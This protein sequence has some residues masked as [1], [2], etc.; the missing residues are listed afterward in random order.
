MICGDNGQGK[1][2]LLEGIA[3]FSG[4]RSFRGAHNRQMICR[5]QEYARLEADFFAEK[6]SQTASLALSADKKELTLNGVKQAA[7]SAMIG[8]FCCVVFSPDRMSLISGG[9]VE[10]RRFLDAAIS[11]CLPRFVSVLYSYN[12]TLGHRNALLKSICSGSAS[13]ADLGLWDIYASGYAADIALKR[14]EYCARLSKAAG[15]IYDGIS[16]GRERLELEYSCSY[17]KQGDSREDIIRRFTDMLTESRARDILLGYTQK[18][19]QRDDIIIK[20]SGADIR[21]YGSRGQKRSA[22]LALKLA[23]AELLSEQLEEKPIALLDDVMSELDKYR[24]SYLLNRLDDWQVYIT[25]C[26]PGPLELLD[27]GRIFF[28]SGGRIEISGG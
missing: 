9:A 27:K 16:S 21:P 3:L 25:C 23:E 22:V 19:P 5:D 10:R 13:E 2:N 4:L 26:D 17:M 20:L 1:T 14:N 6:R 12:Q 15:I 11:Q 18:G 8:R 24:Q 7:A 28:V